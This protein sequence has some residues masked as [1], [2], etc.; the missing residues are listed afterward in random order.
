M[1]PVGVV[2]LLRA[3]RGRAGDHGHGARGEVVAMVA[4]T[5][6]LG[7]KL[8]KWFQPADGG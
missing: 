7:M 3:A 1:V 6:D 4:H 8:E 2:L 5:V